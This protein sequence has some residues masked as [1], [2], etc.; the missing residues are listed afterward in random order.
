MTATAII[1]A[2]S[3]NPQARYINLGDLLMQG[4]WTWCMLGRMALAEDLVDCV[5]VFR[6]GRIIDNLETRRSLNPDPDAPDDHAL[7]SR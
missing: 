1:S 7:R 4:G 5:R 6:Q 2:A 3:T